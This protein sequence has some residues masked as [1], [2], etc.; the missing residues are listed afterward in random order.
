MVQPILIPK[1]VR[2]PT[3]PG[4]AAA[5]F[6]MSTN[7]TDPTDEEDSSNRLGAHPLGGGRWAFRVWAPGRSSVELRLEPPG[8]RVVPMEPEADGRWAAVVENVE[9]W[10][11][12]RYVLDGKTARPDP[13]SSSQP[14][15]VHGPSGLVDHGSFRWD[16]SRWRGIELEKLVLYELH[17]GTFSEQGTFDGAIP[18]LAELAALGVNAL[19]I[20]PVAQFPG[21]RNW[22]YDGA[23]PFAVQASY[24]GSSGLKRL[25]NAA[26]RQGLAVILDVVYNHLGPEGNYLGDFGPYF[27]D[28]YRTPWGSAVNF[29]GPHSDQVRRF[30]VENALTWL[31]DF[32]VDGLR[33]DAV[34]GM[35]DFSAV[36]FLADL[37]RAVES[38]SA[39]TGR[40]MHLIAESDLNDVRVLRSRELGGFGLDAQWSDDFH[41]CLHVLLTGEREGYYSDFSGVGDL[42]AA[43]NEA[44]V[45][46][47][48]RSAFRGRRHGNSAAGVLGRSFVVCA[49]N[50]DQ[51][52]NRMLGDRL[53]TLA[54]HERQKLA[55]GALLCAPFVPLLFMGEEY[56]ETAPFLYFVSHSDEGLV[57]AVREGR[58]REFEH[59]KWKG[60]PPDPQSPETFERSR[61]RWDS[62]KQGRHGVL[63]EFHRTFLRLRAETPSLSRL[64]REAARAQADEGRRTLR[65]ERGGA[66]AFMNF[67]DRPQD[68]G[69]VPPG[70]WRKM[71]DSADARWEGPGAS[72]PETLSPGARIPPYSIALYGQGS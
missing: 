15:G 22:G 36:P 13:A 33:L 62:R 12:Y 47:G 63:L 10:T 42:A 7:P 28:R 40:T 23:Y 9:A 16:D 71:I 58:R 48:R 44:F 6:C 35:F 38:L 20:M 65:L 56:G 59:F 60:E 49:Q 70:L 57:R 27:T 26:H 30:F 21:E 37:S 41:H 1:F 61:L 24:G 53:S 39:E 25:V 5:V 72:M 29:D 34:H 66:V 68:I 14:Q 18:R 64:D 8:A 2:Y 43:Y 52:G 31:R 50:H 55:A 3:R 32:H 4:V 67:S 11:L 17:V 45:Y 54:D 46:S 51:V 69:A 19:Q